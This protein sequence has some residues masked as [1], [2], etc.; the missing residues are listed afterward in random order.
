MAGE[1]YNEIVYKAAEKLIASTFGGGGTPNAD[2]SIDVGGADGATRATTANP[3]PTSSQ[4]F[5]FSPTVNVTPAAAGYGAGDILQGALTLASAG[6]TAGGK[7]VILGARLLIPITAVPSAM[8]TF[9]LHLYSVTPP[10]ALADNAVWDLPSGDRASYLG[11]VALGNPVDVGST[12]YVE[13]TGINKPITVASGGSLFGYLV[14]T[15]AYTAT[16]VPYV[17]TLDIAQL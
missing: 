5:G 4:G 17:V 10:S 1:P 14:T 3:L 15:G 2:G 8:T 16:A 12:L 13:T 9:F 7:L 6:P 11:S